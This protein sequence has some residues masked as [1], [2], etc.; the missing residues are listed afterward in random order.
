MPPAVVGRDKSTMR[1]ILGV[2]AALVVV[3]SLSA[4]GRTGDD[5]IT[6]SG[7]P[8]A[9]R[10]DSTAEAVGV[11]VYFAR[12]GAVATAGRFVPPPAVA[13]GAMEALLAGPQGIETEIGMG[14]EIPAGTQLLGLDVAD[15]TATVD[16]SGAFEAG[17]GSLSMQVR[18]A[19]VVF[20]LTQF[21]TVDTVRF[22]IDGQ[23]VEAIGG[24][25]V[26]VD[27]VD[28]SSFADVTPAVLV[29]SPVPG[30]SVASPLVVTGMANTFEATVN[31]AVTDGDGLIVDEGFTTATAGMGTFGDFT[32]TS[33]FAVPTPG[34]GSVIAFEISAR[35]GSQINVYEVP[36]QMTGP[37]ATPAPAAPALTG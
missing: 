2:L 16:L 20:T 34:L 12:A 8:L 13:Q 24:E 35:D 26:L 37:A 21:E 15:G 6:I 4:C 32:V 23:P 33:T 18:V 19:Q 27:G 3:V 7:E 36:V 22:R 10:V 30:Q 25:G 28:R 5:T 9:A 1:K 14:T 11:R 29:E 17:G 31:Y